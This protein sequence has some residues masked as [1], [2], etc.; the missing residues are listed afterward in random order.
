MPKYESFKQYLNIHYSEMLFEALRKYVLKQAKMECREKEAP[1]DFKNV[2]IQNGYVESVT[3]TKS[4]LEYVEFEVIIRVNYYLEKITKDN[5]Q[6]LIP[7]NWHLYRTHMRGGFNT[8]FEIGG[9]KTEKIN[10]KPFVEKLTNALV[11]VI[12]RDNMELYAT[13]FLKY[14]CPE[15]LE[16]PMALDLT[17]ILNAKGVTWHV[18]P[19]TSG[20]F[21]KTYFAD[22]VAEIY[23]ENHQRKRVNIKRGTILINPLKAEERGPGAL[24]NTIVHEAV[25]WFY[26]NNYFAL[27]HLLNDEMTCVICYK[28]EKDTED[29][30]LKWM[31]MQARSLAP[32]ILLPKKMFIKKYNELYKINEASH[33][34]TD[35]LLGLDFLESTITDLAN[36]F[37]VSKLS[38]KYRLIELGQVEADGVINYNKGIKRYY[39]NYRFNKK[40]LKAHQTFHLP[41]ESFVNLIENDSEI[42]QAIQEGKLLYIDG[43]VVVNNPKYVVNGYLTAYGISHV[44]ECC[45]IFNTYSDS[46]P[47]KDNIAKF[48][49]CSS[50]YRKIQAQV[51]E[52]QFIQIIKLADENALHFESH[53]EDLPSTFGKTIDYH[54][55]KSKQSYEWVANACDLS[56]TTLRKYRDD[57]IDDISI[58][59]IIK[60]G[61]GLKLSYPYIQD[62]LNKA[63]LILTRNTQQNNILMTVITTLSGLGMKQ[64]YNILKADHKEEYLGLSE[65]YIKEHKL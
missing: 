50:G 41:Q 17:K 54:C 24:R 42:M 60:F 23:D 26:H 2:I 14:Y 47:F 32:K 62:L 8:G 55:K 36:F 51:D 64:V 13:K 43:L 9:G 53:K 29:E 5:G 1:F 65:S 56:P 52:D 57:K 44:D 46:R 49:L 39:R 16:T 33:D 3:F 61:L 22:D 40:K 12:S 38:A 37:E 35:W 45:L 27:R 6:V 63:G 11:H 25:H 19:L 31:E 4:E 15:A 59:N 28:S 18:A 10:K 48:S 58:V 20:V 30:D 34:D 7:G 21:G